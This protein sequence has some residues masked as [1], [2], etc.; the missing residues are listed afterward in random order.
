MNTRDGHLFDKES[1]FDELNENRP[2]DLETFSYGE[3]VQVKSGFFELTKIDLQK[4]RLV[5]KPIPRPIRDQLDERNEEMKRRLHAAMDA[6]EAGR[7]RAVA[8]DRRWRVD[9]IA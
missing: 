4:Q 9:R 1:I 6:E 3:T 5:L 8:G 7:H 2:C